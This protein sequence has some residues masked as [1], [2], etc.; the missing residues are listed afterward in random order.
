MNGAAADGSNVIRSIGVVIP[1]RDEELLL[2]G[3][4]A[5]IARAVQDLEAMH[6]D[7]DVSVLVVAD[8]CRDATA[9]RARE[10]GVAVLEVAASNVGLARASGVAAMLARGVDWIG[11]TD[12]D[13]RVPVDWLIEQLSL[14]RDGADAILGRVQPDFRDLD[15]AHEAAW[16]ATHDG[17]LALGNIYGAN[18]GFSSRA[19]RAAGGYRPLPEHEDVDLVTRLRESGAR[20]ADSD[21]VVITSGRLLGRTPGGYARFLRDDLLPLGA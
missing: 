1:A 21:S 2:P 10:A 6:P 5:S 7:V 8:G 12:A 18:L 14:A 20:V 19:Y 3:C 16:H 13:S 17:A 9:A 15:A 4:L 11:S